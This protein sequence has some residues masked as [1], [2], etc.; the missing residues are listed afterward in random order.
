MHILRTLLL[1]AL[2]ATLTVGTAWAGNV[3]VQIQC[4]SPPEI[5]RTPH[6]V[7]LEG[8][9]SPDS[10]ST[11]RLVALV[12]HIEVLRIDGT[13]ITLAS[14]EIDD[15]FLRTPDLGRIFLTVSEEAP[16]YRAVMMDS[17]IE[18]IEQIRS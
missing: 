13:P 5:A 3:F 6:S 2:G 8:R 4:G 14:T 17:Q 18:E 1:T 11:S 15:G 9:F 7:A 12:G 16:G 10:S